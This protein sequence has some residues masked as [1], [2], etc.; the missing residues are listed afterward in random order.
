MATDAHAHVL[1]VPLVMGRAVVHVKF[2]I[3][4]SGVK[5]QRPC[6][7][8]GWSPMPIARTVRDGFAAELVQCAT[9]LLMLDPMVQRN[10]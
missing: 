6:Q 10:T 7:P 8:V 5:E 2:K 9:D 1:L 4:V 3:F